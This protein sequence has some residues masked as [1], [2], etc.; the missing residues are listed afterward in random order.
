MAGNLLART[1]SRA[2]FSEALGE[3]AFVRALLALD[4]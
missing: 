3:D 1:L 2:S 4:S